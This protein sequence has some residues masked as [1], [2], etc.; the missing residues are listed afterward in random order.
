VT[1]SLVAGHPVTLERTESIADGLLAVRPGELTF[2]HLRR[3]LDAVVTVEETAIA[4]AVRWLF[5]EAR[6]VAEPSGA[7]SVAGALARLGKDAGPVAA[8]ISGGNVD[9]ARFVGCLLDG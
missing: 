6:L 8:V 7:V 5:A 2:E 9:P 1:A 4:S 3:Y